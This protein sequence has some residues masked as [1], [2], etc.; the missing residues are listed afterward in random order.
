MN[1]PT[2][3]LRVAAAVFAVVALLQ[4]LRLVM[5]FEITVDGHIVPFWP[6]AIALIVA[7]GLSTWMWR[8]STVARF[9]ETH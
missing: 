7:A 3:G 8:L 4:L 5:Q 9:G 6:N 1:S 2:N